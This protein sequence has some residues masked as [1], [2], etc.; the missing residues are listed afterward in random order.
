MAPTR[1]E[2]AGSG[3][4]AAVVGSGEIAD[5]A[6]ATRATSVLSSVT[7]KI[8][9]GTVAGPRLVRRLTSPSRAPVTV[10][11]VQLVG[12]EWPVEPFGSLVEMGPLVANGTAEPNA[13][14]GRGSPLS[15][16]A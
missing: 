9:A 8:Q 5:G 4:T 10:S 6:T 3:G 16:S 2:S 14:H 12:T 1:P 7:V 13:W 11:A 15:R